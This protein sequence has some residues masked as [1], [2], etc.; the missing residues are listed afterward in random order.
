M[1]DPTPQD[2]RTV[3]LE[4][5]QRMTEIR[6]DLTTLSLHI[7]AMSQVVDNAR[8]ELDEALSR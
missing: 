2:S 4:L 6:D 5:L 1:A 8:E 7:I 3:L